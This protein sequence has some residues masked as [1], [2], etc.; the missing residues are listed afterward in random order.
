MARPSTAPHPLGLRPSPPLP[1]SGERVFA[2]L[3]CSPLRICRG[4]VPRL[5]QPPEPRRH[6]GDRLLVR[7]RSGKPFLRRLGEDRAADREALHGRLRAAAAKAASSS[8][9]GAS[10]PSSTMPRQYG[11]FCPD[12]VARSR[13]RRRRLV[14][15][16]SFH[17]SGLMPSVEP[18]AARARRC[19]SASGAVLAGDDLDQQFAADRARRVVQREAASRSCRC[20]QLRRI[21][22]DGRSTGI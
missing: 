13:A 10:R 16:S 4:P 17:Q 9:S 8:S 1:A 14:C 22:R 7:H 3:S 5:A 2:S 15:G 11:S 20:L 12:H 6:L 18:L 19:R 21:V